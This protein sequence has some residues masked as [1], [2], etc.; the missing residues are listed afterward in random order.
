MN[1]L[2]NAI[3]AI[4]QKNG[5]GEIH[6]TTAVLKEQGAEPR[7]T[8]SIRDTGTG[9]PPDKVKRIFDPF[10]TTK[11]VGKGTGLGLSISHGIVEKH[12]GK[13]S[14]DSTAGEGSTFTV[15]LPIGPR[16]G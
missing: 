1:L 10:Y 7:V 5:P 13:I 4:A 2:L 12:G 16:A 8:V 14:V 3:D 11:P 9:I 6:I 15:E